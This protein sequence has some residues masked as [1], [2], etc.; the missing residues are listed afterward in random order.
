MVDSCYTS[1]LDNVFEKV[2]ATFETAY[3]YDRYNIPLDK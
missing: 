3:R 1:I 2:K